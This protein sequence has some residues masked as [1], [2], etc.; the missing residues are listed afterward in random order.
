MSFLKAILLN[1]DKTISTK[2]LT[3]SVFNVWLAYSVISL[4]S[5]KFNL[6]TITSLLRYDIN[7]VINGIPENFLFMKTFI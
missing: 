1:A 7:S 6:L 4:T 5:F 3:Y 2:K